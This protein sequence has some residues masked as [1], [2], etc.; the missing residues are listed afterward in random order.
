M[1]GELALYNFTLCGTI[2]FGTTA[3]DRG[4]LIAD[5]KDVRDALNMND[6]TGE[7]LGFFTDRSLR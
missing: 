1:Y 3:L 5:I 4:T 7:I 6:A 2:E